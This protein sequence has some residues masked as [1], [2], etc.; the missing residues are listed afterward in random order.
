ME[1]PDFKGET[2]EQHGDHGQQVG[3]TDALHGGHEFPLGDDIDGIDMVDPLVTV[4]IALMNSVDSDVTGQALRS[5]GFAD[6]D[7]DR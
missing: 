6:A 1:A 3:L 7:R 5:G 4:P 2:I